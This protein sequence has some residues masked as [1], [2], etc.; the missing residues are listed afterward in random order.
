M[1]FIPFAQQTSFIRVLTGWMI[2]RCAAR[3]RELSDQGSDFKFAINRVASWPNRCRKRVRRLG[4]GMVR[5]A[6]NASQ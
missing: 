6:G 5:T 3:G 2:E 4:G 1:H